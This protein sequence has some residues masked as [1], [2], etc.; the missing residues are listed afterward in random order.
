M[1]SLSLAL[2]YRGETA[3]AGLLSSFRYQAASGDST[4]GWQE[5]TGDVWGFSE[6]GPVTV[7]L[8]AIG[9]FGGGDQPDIG[10]NDLTEMAFGGMLDAKL[11]KDKLGV[12]VEGGFATGDA[13]T[14]DSK[15]HTFTFNRD[16]NVGLFLF[17]ESMPT[18]AAGVATQTNGGVDTS[19]AQSG[20][21]VSNAIY[22]KPSASYLVRPDLRAQLS[23]LTA[24]KAK[25][26]TETADRKGYG[27]EFDLDLRYDPVPHVWVQ[28]TAAIFVPGK[29]YS[30]YSSDT[31]GDGF[32]KT[33]FGARLVG[34]VEF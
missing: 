15:L 4:S 32:G 20:D 25:P 22:L 13:D 29:L 1:Q 9:K 8:E 3:G 11:Q 12:G 18:L 10:G 34:T 5:Y 28:G 31:L 2:A 21:G 33:V 26:T 14:G 24:T 27:N 19:V 7:N 30:D 17:E 23:W 6:L 16:H